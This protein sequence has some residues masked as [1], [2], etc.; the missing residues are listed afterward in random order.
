MTTT[1]RLAHRRRIADYSL[2]FGPDAATES[3]R[4]CWWAIL[5]VNQ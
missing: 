2:T 4:L 1:T 3:G 5:G